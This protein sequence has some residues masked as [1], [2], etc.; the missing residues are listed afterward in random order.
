[1]W[2]NKGEKPKKR[3]KEKRSR[4]LASVFAEKEGK[5]EEEADPRIVPM[6]AREKELERAKEREGRKEVLPFFGKKEKRGE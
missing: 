1:M 3:V 2:R 6:L 4:R 5:K